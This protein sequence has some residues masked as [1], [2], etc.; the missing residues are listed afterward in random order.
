MEGGKR[1]DEGYDRLMELDCDS[2][3]VKRDSTP[4]GPFC[5]HGETVQH[6]AL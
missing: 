6:V 2:N 3:T 5:R 1:S 4:L